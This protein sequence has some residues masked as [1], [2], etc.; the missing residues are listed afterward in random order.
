MKIGNRTTGED[1]ESGMA[2]TAEQRISYPFSRPL[3]VA[4]IPPEGMKMAIRADQKE[5]AALAEAN[6]LAEVL[7]L[8]ADFTIEREASERFKVSGT[9]CAEVRQT[10][11]LSLEEFNA[12]I[13]APIEVRFAPPIETPSQVRRERDS[14]AAT[15]RKGEEEQE[16]HQI[17]GLDEEAPDPL[18]GG[19]I[20]LGA[21]AAEFLTLS[22][23]PY[24]R[25]PGASFTGLEPRDVNVSI[26]PFAKLGGTLKKGGAG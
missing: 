24:P 11:V 23:D 25:K 5:C 21:V 2:R 22:L 9:L 13:E 16:T 26:S 7:S 8:E 19:M 6:N 1:E 18:V 12:R 15:R 17:V 20:D 14:R 3:S 10:C 4:E